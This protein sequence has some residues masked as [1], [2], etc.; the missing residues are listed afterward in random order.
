MILTEPVKCFFC[1]TLL[2]DKLILVMADPN[3]EMSQMPLKQLSLVLV[4]NRVRG[5]GWIQSAFEKSYQS[6][7]QG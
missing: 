4:W 3:S 5:G 1:K 6:L 7:R 2:P